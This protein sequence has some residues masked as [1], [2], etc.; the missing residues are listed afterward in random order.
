[1]GGRMRLLAMLVLL[2]VAASPAEAGVSG[3]YLAGGGSD[4]RMLLTID[5]P[6]PTAF[7][8]LQQ[9]PAG[10]QMTSASPEP[11]PQEGTAVKWLFKRQPPGSMIITL[12]LSHQV[13]ETLLVGEISYRHP[14]NGALVTTTI[15]H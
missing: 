7:I 10:V 11:A 12:Q 8:V 6:A 9:L 5:K 2:V 13:P 15:S 3:R 1:M 14:A 4:V